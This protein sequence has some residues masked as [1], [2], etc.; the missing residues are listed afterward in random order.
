MLSRIADSMFWMSRYMA[1]AEDTARLLDVTYHMLL[2]QS[3]ESYQLRWDGIITITGEQELFYQYYDEATPHNVFEFLAFREDNANSVVSCLTRVR[4]NARAIRDRISREMW[5]NINGLYHS[6]RGFDAEGEISK[7]PHR[8]CTHIV[9]GSHGFHGVTDGTLPRNEGWYFLEAGRALERAETTT[10]IVDVEY[11]KLLR[12][13]SQ[14]A[15]PDSHQWMAVL[16]SVSAYEIY[17]REYHSRIDP[18]KVAELLILHPRHPRSIRFNV[19]ALQNAL[20]SISGA[21]ANTYASEAERLTGK[22]HDTLVYDR[23]EEIFARG[24]HPFLVDLLKTSRM[25]GENIARKY[26]YYA[27]VA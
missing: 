12:S 14:V 18:Q 16:K 22:L 15:Q 2:E 11:H 4:E 1:R 26:F 20:R 5:E 19:A 23:I 6:V 8:F 10:R 3:Q 9:F 25:I 17:R 27:G 24:L 21:T 13:S 7:G